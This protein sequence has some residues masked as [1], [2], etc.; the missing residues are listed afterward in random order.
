MKVPNES[1]LGPCLTLPLMAWS[2]LVELMR[3]CLRLVAQENPKICDGLLAC[4]EAD[5][6]EGSY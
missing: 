6:G 3:G 2:M 4:D 5:V 1:G